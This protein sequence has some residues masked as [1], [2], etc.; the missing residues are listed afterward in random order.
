MFQKGCL[1]KM[2]N[3]EK[4]QE[5]V[6]VNS[7]ADSWDDAIKEWICKDVYIIPNGGR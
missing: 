1:N 3:I 7:E 5:Q 2:N 6:L 4:L